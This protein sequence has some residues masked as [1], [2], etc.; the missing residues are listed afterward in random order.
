[1]RL[2]DILDETIKG[3]V[4]WWRWWQEKFGSR[5]SHVAGFWYDT[6]NDQWIMVDWPNDGTRV[7]VIQTE[8]F[9]QYIAAVTAVGSKFLIYAPGRIP[10]SFPHWNLCTS[11]AAGLANIRHWGLTPDSLYRALLRHGAKPSFELPEVPV[12]EKEKSYGRSVLETKSP[13]P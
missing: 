4:P 1:M 11:G 13:G 7:G 3:Y 6:F 8:D 10:N 2:G 5:F 12:S 9:D